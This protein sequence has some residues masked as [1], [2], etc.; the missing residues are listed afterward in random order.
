MFSVQPI[1]DWT[2]PKTWITL[3]THVIGHAGWDHLLGNMTLILLIG[4]ILEEKYGSSKILMMI[5][6]TAVGTGILNSFLFQTGLMGASGVAFML[7]LLASVANL[8]KG[9]IPLT[10]VAVTVIFLGKEI[11]DSMEEDNISQFGHIVGGI[12]GAG[13]G[14][15][16]GGKNQRIEPVLPNF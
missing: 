4:P 9:H 1:T 2:A 8:R 10:F 7:I 5:V 16:I 11:L 6:V 14:F 12:L 3:V 13:F 15:M